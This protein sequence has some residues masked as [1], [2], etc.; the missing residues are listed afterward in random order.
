M[1]Q[2]WFGDN[3]D[4]LRNEIADETVDLIYLDP[5]FNSKANYNVLFKSPKGRVAQA[6]AAAF[7][8]T[9]RWGEPAQRCF[10]EVI[11]QG[12]Q[13]AA[14]LHALKGPFGTSQMMAYLANMTVR[15]IELRRVL[16]PT[17]SLYLHC[18]PTASHYIKIILDAI[19]G[20][21]HFTN[22]IVWGRSTPK[23]HATTRFASNHDI[24]FFYRKGAEAVWHPQFMPHREAYIESH[25]RSV[26]ADTG[27]RYML[28]NCLNPNK[29]RPNLTYEW[30][31]HLRVW[32][33]TQ[34]RMQ[35]HHDEG[36]LVYSA[37]GMPRYKRYLD[38]MQGTPVGSRWDDIP[39][40]NSQARERLGY[41]TQ[42]P[43]PLLERIVAA[44]SN[45]GDLV[46]DPF[47]GCGTAVHAAEKLG[48]RWTGIDVTH[49]AIQIIE[50]RLEAEFEGDRKADYEVKGTPT[51]LPEAHKLAEL[52]KHEF[53]LWAA[54]LV[55][56]APEARKKG[57]DRGID[58]L[59]YYLEGRAQTNF[60][61]VSIKG[62]KNLGVSMIR[63]LIAVV[64]QEGAGAGV[65][66]CLE[67]P[68]RNMVNEALDAGRFEV[69][70]THYPKIQIC[71]VED[72]LAGKRPELPP[73]Y[74]F[75]TLLTL[76]RATGKAKKAD[77]KA[78]RQ[79][80]EMLMAF[81]NKA[82]ENLTDLAPADFN[83]PSEERTEARKAG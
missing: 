71:T 49:V 44:S 3:L 34:E 28:D 2:L 75:A 6:Q 25:Y 68:T 27:R 19:F 41:P 74:D 18:D 53:Q 43:L 60:A 65:F 32:R 22:E 12:G 46:L 61:V 64:K 50:G 7:E 76:P 63:E 36:R 5:P 69:L 17:G 16:K 23:S 39:P 13:P 8:D 78:T 56:A 42:K 48:R 21:E 15:L 30:N 73:V 59:I 4:I 26:D 62:G 72:L 57:P 58:G 40:I 66:V 35:R 54:R 70:G 1:N 38:E 31:G 79:Q 55:G 51:N 45:P 37:S 29:N 33:W 67:T 24:I 9:W 47:C 10:D 20:A 77:P 80:L 83:L 82:P 81:V 14:I 11:A 52:D